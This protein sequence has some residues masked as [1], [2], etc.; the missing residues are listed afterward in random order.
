MIA[1]RRQMSL[2]D[3]SQLSWSAAD[4]VHRKLLHQ[5]AIY[6]DFRYVGHGLSESDVKLPETLCDE[7]GQNVVA[8]Y[9]YPR[10]ISMQLYFFDTISQKPIADGIAGVRFSSAFVFLSLSVCLSVCFS[11]R[12]LK[13]RCS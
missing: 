12:H 9:N 11:A 1:V 8:G 10:H 5:D 4:C 6:V 7:V 2:V 3:T 13:H